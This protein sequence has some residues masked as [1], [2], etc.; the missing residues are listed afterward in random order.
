MRILFCLMFAVFLALNT[1]DANETNLTT[2]DEALVK[3]AQERTNA[4]R[5][6]SEPIKMAE[7]IAR[8]C[9]PPTLS[10]EEYR[11]LKARTS[12]DKPHR[13]KF[14]HVYVTANGVN[15]MKT[16][17]AVFPRGT[18]ILKEKLSDAKGQSTELFTGMLKRE[19]GYHPRC[20]DWEFFT[21]SADARQ[22][23][24]RGKLASCV[25]CHIEYRTS[26]YVT[27]NYGRSGFGIPNK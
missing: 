3:F 4:V 26:D 2:S 18:V 8:L 14:V 13:E 5:V 15:A 6:T 25:N 11:I 16:N 20:G 12:L 21:L 23:T 9:G 7:A 10:A 1:L 24:A 27:R 17:T 22:V 19:A